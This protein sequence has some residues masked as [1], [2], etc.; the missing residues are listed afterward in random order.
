MVIVTG[1]GILSNSFIAS[2]EMIL[3]VFLHCIRWHIT[4]INFC[5]LTHSQ[6]RN[7]SHFVIVYFLLKTKKKNKK[8]TT[9]ETQ[10]L[11]ADGT[12]I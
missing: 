9:I 10:N 8:K 11:H 4:L 2:I 1:C 6:T 3:V 5:L 7:K 12:Q